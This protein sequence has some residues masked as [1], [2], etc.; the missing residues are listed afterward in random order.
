M[1]FESGDKLL[2]NR[3][4]YS[5]RANPKP[6][7]LI[8]HYVGPWALHSPVYIRKSVQG[9]HIFEKLNSLSFP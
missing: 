2:T 7:A 4:A 3:F 5:I 1:K 9:D 6:A 8:M